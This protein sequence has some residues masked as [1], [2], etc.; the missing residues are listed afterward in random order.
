MR[1]RFSDTR[2]PCRSGFAHVARKQIV[3]AA[4]EDIALPDGHILYPKTQAAPPRIE[5]EL[6]LLINPAITLT[7][8][9]FM[10]CNQYPFHKDP[11]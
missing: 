8:P 10:N 4:S 5:N 3:Y 2:H 6:I 11:T 7:S 1:G 9:T